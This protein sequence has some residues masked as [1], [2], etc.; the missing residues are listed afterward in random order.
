MSSEQHPPIQAH[1]TLIR[2]LGATAFAVSIAYWLHSY[3]RIFSVPG[4]STTPAVTSV[5]W[6]AGLFAAFALHHSVLARARPKAWVEQHY[7]GHERSIYVIVA[8][9]LLAAVCALWHPLPGTAWSVPKAAGWLVP[10][11]QLATGLWMLVA[12]R[13]LRVAEL[14]GLQPATPSEFRTSGPYG[15]VRHPIYLAWMAVVY[16]LP[17]MTYT[18]LVFAL[19][20]T[21]YILLGI[22][23]E[24]RDLRSLGEPYRRYCRAVRWKLVPFVY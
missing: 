8:S 4:P 17:T 21:L 3:F 16:A 6:N 13:T 24:E 12:V 1:S 9:V 22:V 20:G 7:P 5:A 10:V 18:Q 11:V 19:M 15:I 23:L 14:V 2:M